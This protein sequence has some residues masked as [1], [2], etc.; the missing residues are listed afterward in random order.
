MNEIMNWHLP[1]RGLGLF[2]ELERLLDAPMV[3]AP[4]EFKITPP[5]DIRETADGYQIKVDLP[6]VKKEDLSVQ[7]ADN[8]LTIEAET[9]EVA[10]TNAKNGK[11]S[12]DSE[13]GETLKSERRIGKHA[14]SIWLG[15]AVDEDNIKAD[16]QDGVLTLTL[17]HAQKTAAKRIAVKVH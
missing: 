6:G 16:Y 9:R 2:G 5:M 4:A 3:R 11:G 12:K 8:R 17:P 14:R 13:A 10:V 15:E 1:Q 7:V